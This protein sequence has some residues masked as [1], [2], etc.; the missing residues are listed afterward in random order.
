[1]FKD[2]VVKMG[3]FIKFA[4]KRLIGR[5]SFILAFMFMNIC[6]S[7]AGSVDIMQL[8]DVKIGMRGLGKTVIQGRKIETFEVEVLG[9]LSN[10]KVNEN[11][12]INGKSILVK[13]SG[14]VIR[15][16]GGIAAGMSGSPVY[17]DGKLVGGISSGWIMTDHTVGLVTPIEEMLEIWSYPELA[18]V[19]DSPR[20]W[21]LESPVKIGDKT[22]SAVWEVA[23]DQPDSLIQPA[24]DELVM[25]Q[26]A[27]EVYVDGLGGRAA[28][29]LKSKMKRSNIK[30]AQ[31]DMPG[32]NSG[33]L[34]DEK[35]EP[36]SYEPGSSIGI[37]LARGDINLTTLGTLTHRSEHRILALAH[38]FLKKGSV[39]LLMT[40][41]YIHHSFSSVEMPFK[42]GMPTEMLGIITQDREKGISGEIGR[43]PEMVPV[44]IDVLDKNLQVTRSINYQIVRDPAVFSMVLESTL[45][46]ALEGVID[47]AGAG[48][49]LMGISLD[50]ANTSGEQYNFRRENMFYSR[51]DIVQSLI[52]EVSS[53]IEMVTES[54]IEEV[55]PT[56]LL[57]KIEVEKRR[58]TL[59]IEKVEIK[60]AQVAG[61]GVLDVEITLRPFREEKFIRKVKIPIPQDIGKENLVLSVFGLNMRVDDA[62][63]GAEARD[64]RAARDPRS[65]EGQAVDFD[66]VI[67]SWASSPKNSDLLFQLAVEGDEMKKIKLNGKDLEIQ[68][69]NLVVTG[70]VDTTLTLSEE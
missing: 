58:R 4:E 16:A 7:F 49:A 40:G 32:S 10:N 24:A 60:N 50:C 12:L 59:S 19:P 9:I 23:C 35:I 61:G 17:I 26:A 48:T 36:A 69:T 65:E 2:S 46:Q 34:S 43:F 20:Y 63:G 52:A 11:L 21:Q 3:L 22:F 42:I 67:R 64:A 18:C 14:D 66:S 1:M 57:L 13:V 41:A 39:A 6:Q 55:M 51:T 45:V 62:D 70:R 33:D 28:E 53:L 30:V 31:K 44:Q 25:R 5:F 37:Q 29:V 15:R 8:K 68:P 27:A 56:R 38:P 54:E 47:R